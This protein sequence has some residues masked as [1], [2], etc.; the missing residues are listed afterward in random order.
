MQNLIEVANKLSYSNF[1]D[2]INHGRRRRKRHSRVFLIRRKERRRR[3]LVSLQKEFSSN[4]FWLGWRIIISI[5]V[6]ADARNLSYLFRRKWSSN[7]LI[8]KPIG[9]KEKEDINFISAVFAKHDL[10]KRLEGR[11]V[12]SWDMNVSF[13]LQKPALKNQ[14]KT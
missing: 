9:P 4:S 3:E 1:V 10:R 2:I 12:S 13:P 11:S 8:K 5:H 14:V 7:H 6:I